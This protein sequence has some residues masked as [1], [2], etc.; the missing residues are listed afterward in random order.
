[1]LLLDRKTQESITIVL[2]DDREIE[3]KVI[4]YNKYGVKL[5][6]EAPRSIQIHRTEKMHEVIGKRNEK[7]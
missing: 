1:M 2:E 3:V 7:S 6:F 5:G 4:G